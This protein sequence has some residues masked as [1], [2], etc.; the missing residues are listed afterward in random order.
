MI[1]TDRTTFVFLSGFFFA[2]TSILLVDRIRSVNKAPLVL[3]QPG[4]LPDSASI[5]VVG[6]SHVYAINSASV[7]SEKNFKLAV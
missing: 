7:R 3:L 1:S 6:E 4:L 2:A 5:E